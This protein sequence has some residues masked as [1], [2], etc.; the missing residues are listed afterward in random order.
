MEN[1][2]KNERI[3]GALYFI[4]FFLHMGLF[5]YSE[6]GTNS[7]EFWPFT[8]AGDSLSATYDISEF[9]IY[10]GIP[11]VLYVAFKII[12]YKNFADS[13]SGSRRH[14]N[15]NNFFQAFLDEKIKTEELRQKIN[16]LTNQ[17]VNYHYLDELRKDKEKAAT[18]GVNGWLDRVEVKKKYRDFEK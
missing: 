12:T 10:I 16:E 18:E 5:F 2:S 3:I 1:F 11:L 9:L 13:S 4:W 15:I 7:S 17:P 14:S 6:D 8:N